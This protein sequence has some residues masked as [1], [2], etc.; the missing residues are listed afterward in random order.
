MPQLV[1]NPLSRVEGCGRRLAKFAERLGVPFEYHGLAQRFEEITPAK[2]SLR[3]Y[4]VLAVTCHYR[5]HYLM[6][7]TV[8]ATHP[9]KSVLTTIRRLNPKVSLYLFC[10]FNF[11]LLLEVL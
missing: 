2:I 10:F 3:D 6:D 11:N 1:G 5:L 4:E 8:V 9:R 7:E